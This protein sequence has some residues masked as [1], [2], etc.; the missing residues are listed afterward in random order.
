MSRCPQCPR[1]GKARKIHAKGLCN[2]HYHAELKKTS[3]KR[4]AALTKNGEK[5][6]SGRRLYLSF[7]R[8]VVKKKDNDV[9]QEEYNEIRSRACVICAST[10]TKGK[11]GVGV[12]LKASSSKVDIVTRDDIESV[13]HRCKPLAKPFD[14]YRHSQ[15]AMRRG[16]RRTPY[17]KAALA[18]AMIAPGV[19]RCAGCKGEFP[20]KEIDLDHTSPIHPVDASPLTLDEFSARLFCAPEDL[21]VLCRA[22][23]HKEKTKAE[24]K[25]RKHA[26]DRKKKQ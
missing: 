7:I 12:M 1:T 21:Q 13:C 18:R 9:T 14:R 2:T 3:P 8:W 11:F 19:V 17:A 4:R 26:R 25:E 15:M 20:V 5:Y 23:C 22:K 24:N 10:D 16:W 6:D